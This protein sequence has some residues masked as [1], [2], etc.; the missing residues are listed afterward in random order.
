MEYWNHHSSAESPG[1][2]LQQYRRHLRCVACT[3]SIHHHVWWFT[4]NFRCYNRG[5]LRTLVLDGFASDGIRN[6]IAVSLI[7]CSLS[8]LVPLI[9]RSFGQ[10]RRSKFSTNPGNAQGLGI[11]N[12]SDK[13]SIQLESIGSFTPHPG[14]T[15]GR[16]TVI[17][18][19]QESQTPARS[20]KV[21]GKDPLYPYNS[22]D[23]GSHDNGKPAF[24]AP[25]A[26]SSQAEEEAGRRGWT[27]GVKVAREVM[28]NLPLDED[29]Y[30]HQ[31]GTVVRHSKTSRPTRTDLEDYWG[32]G[33]QAIREE[34]VSG[35]LSI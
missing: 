2:D 28:E 35:F 24:S 11:S 21:Y 15:F 1:C 26:Y 33:I 14:H 20:S 34:D 3:R 18:G 22:S 4:G 25:F 9:I 32:S 23:G 17:I 7:V 29:Q 10:G 12:S 5:T 16:V 19:P 31:A 8:V 6:K 13:R 30:T 27:K